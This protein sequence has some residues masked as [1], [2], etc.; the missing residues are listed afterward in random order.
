MKLNDEKFWEYVNNAIHSYFKI[1][2]LF[3]IL[4]NNCGKFNLEILANY[5]F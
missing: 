2:L 3:Q 4:I 5:C 1:L